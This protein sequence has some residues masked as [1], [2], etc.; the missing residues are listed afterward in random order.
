VTFNLVCVAWIFF[1]ATSLK[2]AL[3]FL[4]SVGTWHWLPEYW[5]ALSFLALFSVP[6]FALDL[7]LEATG[8]EYL[9]AHATGARRFAA[10]SAF[11]VAITFFAGNELNAF[12]YFQL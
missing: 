7:T 4:G 2:Q 5:T 3:V 11:L 9:F 1:R 8:D 12:I 10:A 6:L